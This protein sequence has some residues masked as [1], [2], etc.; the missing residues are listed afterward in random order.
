VDDPAGNPPGQ[1]SFVN[2]INDLGQLVGGYVDAT[3]LE[4]GF[5]ATPAQG[6]SA[7]ASLSF[8]PA[9]KTAFTTD[10]APLASSLLSTWQPTVPT[11]PLSGLVPP[12]EQALSPSRRQSATPRWGLV[13]ERAADAVFAASQA[14]TDEDATRLFAAW[15]S[16]SLDAV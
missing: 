8:A 2:G 6:A 1:G 15:D 13:V 14:G 16:S 12:R 5:L 7:S 3:G 11:G 10:S 9:L 4:H